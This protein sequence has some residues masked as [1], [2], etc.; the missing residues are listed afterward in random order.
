MAASSTA[1]PTALPVVMPI[2]VSPAPKIA[3]AIMAAASA[4]RGGSATEDA[5]GR[6]C[7]QS[8]WIPSSRRSAGPGTNEFDTAIVRIRPA[9]P[10]VGG[11]VT[12]R[13]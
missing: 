3:A 6:H 9:R 5:A 12:R 2:S 13:S 4:R 10:L 8:I 7:S 1:A 11:T